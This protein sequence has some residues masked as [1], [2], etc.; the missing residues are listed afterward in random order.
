M[1][2]AHRHGYSLSRPTWSLR[3]MMAEWHLLLAYVSCKNSSYLLF[4]EGWFSTESMSALV[5]F[6]PSQT[7]ST[8]QTEGRH[9]QDS[10]QR[11]CRSRTQSSKAKFLWWRRGW[12]ARRGTWQEYTGQTWRKGRGEPHTSTNFLYSVPFFSYR[13]I[14]V[15]PWGTIVWTSNQELSLLSLPWH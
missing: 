2:T 5:H 12:E 3:A 7:H 9:H 1:F 4:G 14:N 6:D 15:K 13:K 10:I 8:I 11:H